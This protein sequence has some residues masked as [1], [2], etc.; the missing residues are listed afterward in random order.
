MISI[1]CFI[2]FVPEVSA[3]EIVHDEIINAAHA[4]AILI[5]QKARQEADAILQ[6][7]RE[8]AKLVLEK[9]SSF[10]MIGPNI[11]DVT[12]HKDPES[13]HQNHDFA[14]PKTSG[15]VQKPDATEHRRDVKRCWHRAWEDHHWN[16]ETVAGVDQRCWSG[17]ISS[18]SS[19][20][21]E[22]ESSCTVSRRRLTPS[23]QPIVS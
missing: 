22:P 19:L 12:M 18:G 20:S 1:Y 8:D 4:E 11:E 16:S 9:A 14:T 21:W 3:A 2:E 6:K 23:V 13:M 15:Y 10:W 5:V 7:S 17:N